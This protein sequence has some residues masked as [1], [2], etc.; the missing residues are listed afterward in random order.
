M[1]NINKYI[2]TY[3]IF[4]PIDYRT[5]KTTTNEF[6][7]YLKG[8]YKSETSRFDSKRLAIYFSSGKSSANIV[9][10]QFDELKIKHEQ[11]IDGESEVVYIFPEKDLDKVHSILKFQTKGASI[12][13]T[14]VKTS[15]R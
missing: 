2:G 11:Y 14:S 8:K 13:P 12:K 15:R 4:S 5:G 1:K 6:D 3:R 10:P 7:T 9:L